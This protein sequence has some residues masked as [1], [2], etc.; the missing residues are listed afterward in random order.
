[1]T[2]I[3]SQLTKLPTTDPTV[4]YYL[5]AGISA[6]EKAER[7]RNRKLV[8]TGR[9]DKITDPVLREE[10]VAAEERMRES[11]DEAT[12]AFF[13]KM[14]RLVENFKQEVEKTIYG[15][16]L[17]AG[18]PLGFTTPEMLLSAASD[19]DNSAIGHQKNSR[20]YR[21]LAAMGRPN[22][23]M[24]HS[25]SIGRAESLRASIFEDA[26]MLQAAE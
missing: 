11:E 22:T 13:Q 12:Q 5:R 21:E 3:L 2:D 18:T 26:E 15:K 19:E 4:Q 25:V 9:A 14:G 1:M 20:F 6:V 10:L 17:V 16:W 24:I 8:K 23:Q 7:I